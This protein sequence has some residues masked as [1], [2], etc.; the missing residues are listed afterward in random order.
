MKRSLI[1]AICVVAGA[2][3]AFA[4]SHMSPDQMEGSIKARKAVM[5]LYAFNLG[6]LGGMA[7]G[8]IEYDAKVASAAAD[9]LYQV[10]TLNQMA[11]WPKGSDNTQ[12]E[13]TRALPAIWEDMAGV[14]AAAKAMEESAAAMKDAAGTDLAALRGAIG[15]VGGACGGCHK[16]YRG[17]E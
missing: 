7:K 4:G 12:F 9:N 10:V 14:G 11:L 16:A 8:V 17:P 6:Q 5:Q 1:A 15:A 3:S 2:T 13:S